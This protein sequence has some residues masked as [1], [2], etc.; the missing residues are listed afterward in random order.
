MASVQLELTGS[1]RER[2]AVIPAEAGIQ[3]LLNL[4]TGPRRCDVT[5]DGDAPGRDSR[6][7]V[8]IARGLYLITCNFGQ[9]TIMTLKEF[10]MARQSEPMTWK[11]YPR[12]PSKSRALPYG[13][14]TEQIR[15]SS[16]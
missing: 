3:R 11:G 5:R 8:L 15:G 9:K 1:P 14:A 6:P 12:G 10:Y 7:S 4:D 16:Q 13:R 2:H